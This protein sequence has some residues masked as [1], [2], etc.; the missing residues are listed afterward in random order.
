[1]IVVPKSRSCMFCSGNAS[2]RED[3]WPT[4]LRK[5]FQSDD[6]RVFAERR[7]ASL[8][9]WRPG[10][11]G[12]R[13]KRVCALCNNGW[14]SGL[15]NDA[16]PLVESILDDRLTCISPGAQSTLAIW[17]MKTAMV[18]EGVDSQDTWFYSQDERE[19]L[20][21]A[22]M[23][24]ERTAVF[25]AK[26]VAQPH[27]YSAAKNHRTPA[28]DG[29]IRAH[30]TTVAFGPV[31]FQVVTIRVPSVV[32]ANVNVTYDVSAGPW[33]TTLVQMWPVAQQSLAWPPKHGLEGD[34]GLYALTERLNPASLSRTI[35]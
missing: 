2:T 9:S 28:R 31:A 11:T 23:L 5:R 20:R 15:E 16:K 22:R 35:P 18:H 25:I 7:G 6:A 8:G 32:P 27:I 14:M 29:D 13:V 26:C 34:D 24:P 3:V 33:E 10:N 1:M 17:S 30:V 19:R 12:L 21:T 4:W